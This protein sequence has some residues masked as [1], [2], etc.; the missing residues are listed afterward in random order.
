MAYKH[1]PKKRIPVALRIKRR[2]RHDPMAINRDLDTKTADNLPS[3]KDHASK[4]TS[5]LSSPFANYP[6]QM[7]SSRTRKP[8]K[9]SQYLA[10][11]KKDREYMLELAKL[12]R[13]G[14]PQE[15]IDLKRRKLE[16]HRSRLGTIAVEIAKEGRS[17]ASPT[18]TAKKA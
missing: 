11:F 5:G 1:K 15:K 4:V 9:V 6:G 18:G 13:E 8:V 7:G 14:A 2:K 3:V 12:I 10:K 16:A 17:I